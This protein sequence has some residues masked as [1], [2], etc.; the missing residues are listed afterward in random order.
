MLSKNNSYIDRR[1]F[2]KQSTLLALSMSS[3]SFP[4]TAAMGIVV[5]SYGNRWNSKAPSTTFP[6]FSNALELLEHCHTIGAGGLQVGVANWTTESAAELRKKSEEYGMYLEGSI[7]MPHDE[8]DLTRFENEV[9]I[10]REAGVHIIRT[11]ASAGR[12]YETYHSMAEFENA[13]SA[14]LETLQVV[15]PLMAKHKTRLALENH[16]DWLIEEMTSMITEISSPWIGV[17]LDFGNSIA[18]LQDPLEVVNALAPYAFST[19][20]KDMGV[21]SY[22]KGFLLSE[23]PLGTGILELPLMIN[24]CRAR[25]PE[26]RFSLEMITR[27]PLEIPCLTD[28][29]WETMDRNGR[30]NNLKS[31][32]DMVKRLQQSTPLPRVSQM[33]SDARLAEEEKNIV[34]CLTYAHQKL[35]L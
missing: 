21:Q 5:H 25:N 32:L 16:K 23:V 17:T 30:Q 12:R 14:A 7:A 1:S 29:Y 6:G 18:L 2:L 9:R 13:K 3:L 11:V 15:E 31:T 28:G 8:N 19:H 34:A 22:E 33:N 20:V 10:A 4:K 35:A 27:D 26:I 24:K